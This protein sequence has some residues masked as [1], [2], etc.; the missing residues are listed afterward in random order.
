MFRLS[1]PGKRGCAVNGHLPA[2]ILEL[3]L[4]VFAVQKEDNVVLVCSKLYF[5]LR[6]MISI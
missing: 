1:V 2:W 3:Y 5:A 4:L 6:G